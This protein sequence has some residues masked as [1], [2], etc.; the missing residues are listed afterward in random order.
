MDNNSTNDLDLIRKSFVSII[1][2]VRNEEAY[3]TR[4]LGA[5]LSQDYPKDLIEVYVVDGMSV[6]QTRRI[7]TGFQSDHPNVKLLDNP[8]KI[9]SKG[10]NIALNYAKGEIIIRVDGHCEIAPD[11]VSKCVK[12]INQDQVD[13]VGGPIATVGETHLAKAIAT[14]MSS[15]FGVG[16]S[17]FRTIKDKSMLVDTVPFPAYKREAIEKTGRFDE[18]LVRNQDDEYNYRLRKLNGKIL[19]SPDIRSKYYSRSTLLSLWRQYFQYGYWKVRVLQKHPRQ[20]SLRQFIPP[21]FVSAL[22]TLTLIAIAI[23]KGWVLLALV[24]GI[25]GFVNLIV[26][27]SLASKCGWQYF[28]VLPIIYGL[29]H[30]SYGSGFLAGL[31]KFSIKNKVVQV[32]GV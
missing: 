7:V 15:R 8:G 6:D 28:P 19:L 4:S 5:V 22:I 2:P 31:L 1:M 26:S 10:L 13:C 17:A 16:N 24:L 32:R 11:Y 23:P 21:V 30:L 20:M 25:Y 12:Y 9:V 18:E 27:A 3:I 29:L 14:A